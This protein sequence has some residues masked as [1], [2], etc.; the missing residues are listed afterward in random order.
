MGIN[1]RIGVTLWR[2]TLGGGRKGALECSISWSKW[3]L[4]RCF[5]FVKLLWALN[6]WFMHFSVYM[7]FFQK[8]SVYL[9]LKHWF[10][11]V[12]TRHWVDWDRVASADRGNGA[13][14]SAH[15][16]SA[17]RG[18]QWGQQHPRSQKQDTGRCY[19]SWMYHTVEPT[20]QTPLKKIPRKYLGRAWNTMTFMTFLYSGVVAHRKKDQF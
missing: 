15:S 12:S 18:L 6:L 14:G 5:H 16:A 3:W 2:E 7:L 19:M 10:L 8:S 4:H 13:P 9:S 1:M 20:I 11:Q 17:I